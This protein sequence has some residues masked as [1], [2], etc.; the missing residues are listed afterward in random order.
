MVV[1]HDFLEVNLFL[2]DLN[3]ENQIEEENSYFFPRESQ[4]LILRT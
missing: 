3:F 4:L 1:Y 2:D